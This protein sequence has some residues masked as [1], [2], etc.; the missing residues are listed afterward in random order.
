MSFDNID[1]ST[2]VLKATAASDPVVRAK[3][4]TEFFTAVQL[5]VRQAIF[6]GDNT[7]DIFTVTTLPPGVSP[8]IPVDIIAPGTEGDYRAFTN[9][10]KGYI[11]AVMSAGDKFT[12]ATIGDANAVEW[13]LEH[14]RNARW[15]II[16]RYMEALVAGFV[17]KQNDNCWHTL[18]AGVADRGLTVYDAGASVGQF[19]KKLFSLARCAFAR[20]AGGN[21]TS[22]KKGR[23]TDIYLS[24]EGI[25]EI[26]NW[27]LDQVPD[28]VRS[29]LYSMSGGDNTTLDILKVKLHEM[30]ELGVGQEYQTYYTSTLAASLVPIIGSTHTVADIELAVALDLATRD[31]FVLL[32]TQA[33]ELFQDGAEGSALHRQ[34]KGGAYGWRRYGCGVLDTRRCAALSY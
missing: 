4:I 12:L 31:S 16:G 32:E 9:P 26:L 7:S 28:A 34:Q 2:E 33:L 11:P 13:D 5:P 25:E 18:L 17:K 8:E 10:G 1:I 29:Q 20:N 6:D 23:M 14:A 3:A 21:Q 15:D 24:C 19:T 22:L 27:N 30:Y